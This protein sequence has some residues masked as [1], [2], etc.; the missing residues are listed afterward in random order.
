MGQLLVHHRHHL[1]HAGHVAAHHVAALHHVLALHFASR[2]GGGLGGGRER[3]EAIVAA[4]ESAD[5]G[6]ET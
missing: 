5:K 2:H 1:R 3:R 6:R 4:M